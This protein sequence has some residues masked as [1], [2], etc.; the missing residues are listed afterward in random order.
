MPDSPLVYYG[1]RNLQPLNH[2]MRHGF[3]FEYNSETFLTSLANTFYIYFDDKRHNTNGNPVTPAIKASAEY[4][5]HYQ[6][7]ADWKI[8][9]ERQKTVSAMLMLCLNLG[10][11]PPDI[12]KTYPCAKL[13]SWC[14]PTAFSDTKKAIETIGK[15]LQ[16]Q[17]ETLTLRTRYKQSLDPSVEDVKRF[18]NTL[19]RNAKDERILFHYNGHGVPQP[20]SSG[21]IWVFNRGYTQYIPISLYDLQTWLGAPVIFVYDCNS[22]GHIVHNFKK[23]VQKRIDDDNEGNHDISSPSP[24]SSYLDCIQL[25][26]CRSNELLPMTPDLP[27][28]L[29]TC[30]LTCPIDISIKWFIMQSPLRKSYYDQLPRNAVGNVVIPGKLTERRTPLGELNWIFTA[31]TDTIAWTSLSR[32]I[33]KRLFRQ[34]LMVAA[35]FRNFLLAKRIMPLL[36]C[37]PISDPPLP[38]TVRFHTM[39]ESWDLA[40]DQV[41]SQLIRSQTI[42]QSVSS[43]VTTTMATTNSPINSTASPGQH[44]TFFEQQLTAFEIWLKFSAPSTKEPPEQLPIVLQVL[45]S[46]VHRLR[47]LILLSKFLDLGPWAVYLSL[48]IG[49]FPY[50]LKLLQSPAQELKP[51]LIFI[52]ARIMAIDYKSTQQELCKDK[53]YNYFYTILNGSPSASGSGPLINDDHKAMSAFILTLFIKDFKNGQRLCFSV[54]LINNCLRYMALSENP[55]LRQW[56]CLLLSQLWRNY[57]DGKWIIYKDGY[58]SKMLS[59]ASDPIPEVRTAIV[60]G[61]TAFLSDGSRQQNQPQ[62]QGQQLQQQQHGAANDMRRDELRQQD[63]RL[64]NIVL[65]LLGDGSAMVRK[66]II[67]FINKFVAN[68]HQ[69]FLVVAFNQLEEEVV[70]IDNS[71]QLNDFRKKSPAYGSIFSSVWKALLILAEDPHLEVKQLAE[72]LIDTVM[73]QLNES[74]LGPLVR[75]MQMYLLSKSSINISA[76]LVAKR[77]ISSA[78]MV[79]RKNNTLTINGARRVASASHA[80]TSSVHSESSLA[81]SLTNR[82]KGLSLAKLVSSLHINDDTELNNFTRILNSSPVSSNYHAE[83]RPKPPRFTPRDVSADVHLSEESGFFEYSCEYFQEPQM[84]KSELDEPGSQEYIERLWR[85]NRNEAIIQ[86]TQPQKQMAIRG[87]WGRSPVVL[88]NKTQ[89][90]LIKFTQFEKNLVVCDDKDNVTVWDWETG[91]VVNR[92]SNMNPAGTKITDIKFLNEDDS[93]LMLAGS[94]DGVIKIYK[95][96]TSDRTK[97]ELVASWRALTDLLLT[98]K[99][100]GLICEWQQSRGS[101]LVTGDVKIIRVWD[102]PRELCLVDIPARSTSAITSITSDQVA[103]DIFVAGFDDGSLRVYDRRLDPRESM[104]R[105]WTGS[106][107]PNQHQQQRSRVAS[108][109]RNIHMQRGGYRELV[110]GAADGSV[111]LWDIRSSDSVLS[112]AN[113]EKS[114]RCLEVHEHAPIIATGSK[115]VNLWTSS[116]DLVYNLK[117]PHESSTYLGGRTSNYLSGVA[118][119]PH[120]MMVASNY[121]QDGN[122]NV[123]TC[124]DIIQEY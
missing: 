8:M 41:L 70:L 3:E 9:K 108:P 21:E 87:D 66:E 35:L 20:T 36:N 106:S 52:W 18:C 124:V 105:T 92:L 48:S 56:C 27:A 100:T 98:A 42:P 54:E 78:S 84:S 73:L 6:A 81:E 91:K 40:I 45:L 16:S 101:L 95:H 4:A 80:D 17:Y 90:K 19:R 55:L 72:T 96:F 119:H 69:F 64:A 49:I 93:P 116:G 2:A 53:G 65:G 14:D 30:C 43:P 61:M 104:V 5:K 24:T 74:E 47:A 15:N 57:P 77:Q 28:D 76:S 120:R 112:F 110:S 46:Q 94:S 51:V 123:Y 85:R 97:P 11:D 23:F 68:Y 89:P 102:A 31:I 60:L 118:L 39:W 109:I 33:F 82:L 1:P 26:A 63:L 32:P 44:S 86:E 37:N 38:E 29:F 7:I 34:D 12:M 59:M 88:D 13:E 58:L 107:H 99:S 103:G 50:V 117:N 22:A 67:F 114:L 10:V 62:S 83:Y 115:S 122:I 121:N 71:N 79:S 25:A 111:H 75:D 113:T